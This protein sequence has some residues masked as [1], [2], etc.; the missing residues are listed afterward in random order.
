MEIQVDLPGP[1]FWNLDACEWIFQKVRRLYCNWRGQFYVRL[2]KSFHQ[3]LLTFSRCKWR[4]WGPCRPHLLPKH[5]PSLPPW[6]RDCPH[7]L[8]RLILPLVGESNF[9]QSCRDVTECILLVCLIGLTFYPQACF[10]Q[11]PRKKKIHINGHM[12][13]I[14]S[15]IPWRYFF[16]HFSSHH[17]GQYHPDN[18][19]LGKTPRYSCLCI[20]Y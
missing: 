20:I 14:F 3:P 11:L 2:T 9:V 18:D 7:T 4:A 12:L 1:S 6:L 15:N 5:G 19:I 17:R 8:W 16:F 13:S 10:Y